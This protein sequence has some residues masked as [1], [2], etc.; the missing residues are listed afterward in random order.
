MTHE[1]AVARIL[2]LRSLAEGTSNPHERDTAEKQAASLMAA[3]HVT[4]DDLAAGDGAPNSHGQ[5]AHPFD[6]FVDKVKK[7]AAKRPL[8]KDVTSHPLLSDL[9]DEA[10]RDLPAASKDLLMGKVGVAL[11]ASRLLFSNK[12]LDDVGGIYD[13]IMKRKK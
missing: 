1:Q 7:Y 9:L 4:L 10:K 5:T 13:D 3:H 2:K 6:L 11:K 8:A 12:I